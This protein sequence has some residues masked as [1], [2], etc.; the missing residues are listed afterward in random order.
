[1]SETKFRREALPQAR[2]GL[3]PLL[4]PASEPLAVAISSRKVLSILSSL[5]FIFMRPSLTDYKTG[6]IEVPRL[7]LNMFVII[8]V[9]SAEP[10]AYASRQ[11]YSQGA[12]YQEVHSQSPPLGLNLHLPGR[13]F[14]LELDSCE[15]NCA[16]PAPYLSEPAGTAVICT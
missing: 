8:S 6:T 1:M 7:V 16:Q 13:H 12:Q 14:C 3:L 2:V 4:Y 10:A 15:K 5:K 9:A 11:Q